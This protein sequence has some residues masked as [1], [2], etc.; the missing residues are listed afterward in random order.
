[1][2]ITLPGSSDY[3]NIGHIGMTVKLAK[4]P[5]CQRKASFR[6]GKR[7]VES[8]HIQALGREWGRKAVES[9]RLDSYRTV[10]HQKLA[11]R[12]GGRRTAAIPGHLSKVSRA[13]GCIGGRVCVERGTGI[14]GLT[15]EQ[16]SVAGRKGGRVG[17]RA[18]AAIPGHMSRAASIAGRHAV[19]SGQIA[20]LGRAQGRK[21]TESGQIK[22]A[23][24]T[25][26]HVKLNKPNPRCA[27]CSEQ[28]LIVSFA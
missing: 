9:G 23:L 13:G 7:N 5:D 17:G 26:W 27:L 8:G 21:N 25:R 2:N 11:G 6:A 12:F 10:E 20:A 4:D 24:H 19:E 15:P 22:D 28:N 3:K 16:K 1:M 18:T 14:Y